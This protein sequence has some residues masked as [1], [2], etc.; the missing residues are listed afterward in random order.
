M[1]SD[2]QAKKQSSA[3]SQV[4]LGSYCQSLVFVQTGSS[5]SWMLCETVLAT[6]D[7]GRDPGRVQERSS[8]SPRR[9]NRHSIL[10]VV[11]FRPTVPPGSPAG[12]FRSSHSGRSR[13]GKTSPEGRGKGRVPVPSDSPTAPAAGRLRSRGSET[14]R[15]TSSR[16]SDSTRFSRRLSA[17]EKE[18]SRSHGTACGSLTTSRTGSSRRSPSSP[19]RLR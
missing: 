2:H 4:E 16:A 1:N 12:S 7:P 19:G 11:V 8:E 10:H 15:L 13:S 17:S 9:S 14:G 18:S 3:M 6:E 5:L